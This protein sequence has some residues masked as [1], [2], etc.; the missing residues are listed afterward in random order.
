MDIKDLYKI[1]M[2]D[3]VPS[4]TKSWEI[5]MFNT[6]EEIKVLKQTLQGNQTLD[7]TDQS[8]YTNTG[9]IENYHSLLVRLIYSGDNGISSRGQSVVSWD[10]LL[11]A[12]KDPQLAVLLKDMLLNP[13]KEKFDLFANWWKSFFP[14]NNIL[15]INR[16]MAAIQPDKL[17]ST[18]DNPKFWKVY[19]MLI[20]ECEMPKSSN[21]DDWYTINC[22]SMEWLDQQ[23]A[24][25]YPKGGKYPNYIYRN[26]FTWLLYD[27]DESRYSLSKQYIMYGAPGT[28]KT[29]SCDKDISVHYTLWRQPYASVPQIP[30]T[31]NVLNLQFHPSYSYEDFIDGIRPVMKDGLVQLKLVDGLF[32]TFCKSAAVW[33]KDIIKAIPDKKEVSLDEIMVNEIIGKVKGDHW[34]H[35]K[36]INKPQSTPL[37]AVIPPYYVVIDEINRADLSRVFGELMKCLEYRGYTGKIKTQYSSLVDTNNEDSCYFLEKG[38]NFFFIP[39]NLYLVGT[40][41]TIDRSVESFD[42]ALRRRFQWIEVVPDYTLLFY[43]LEKPLRPAV[44]SLRKLNTLI[45]GEPL[46]GKDYCIG[47]A[48]LMKLGNSGNGF[49]LLS[50]K[51]IIWDSSIQPLLEEYLRGSRSERLV[52][53][54]QTAF[55]EIKNED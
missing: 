48:Y 2:V 51:K 14:Q 7:L 43:F 15:L 9:T 33:E 16:T 25:V 27:F 52:E 18:V 4:W 39:N 32:K 1:I 5:N 24:M 29:Y 23:L 41:N 22:H 3:T 35:L 20:H 53:Q 17:S 37:S 45:A 34:S 36:S 13:N 26:I 6:T 55:L 31:P 11:K 19:R 30:V 46:L 47:H 50:F 21:E 12:E 28:G 40:M 42:F 49:D 10:N 54:Y 38:E 8:L 44:E